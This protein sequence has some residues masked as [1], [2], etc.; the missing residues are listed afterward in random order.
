M[1][2]SVGFG[3]RTPTQTVYGPVFTWR[4]TLS[5]LKVMIHISFP[6]AVKFNYTEEHLFHVVFHSV[7]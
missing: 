6:A 5:A 2:D 7:Y 3:F 4:Y 1:S